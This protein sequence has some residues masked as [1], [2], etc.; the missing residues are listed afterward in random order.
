MIGNDI[1][2]LTIAKIES[3]WN[4]PRFLNKIFTEKEQQYIREY[5]RPERMVWLLWS[6]KESAYKLHFQHNKKR[7]YAPKKFSCEMR[8]LNEEEGCGK[9]FFGDF[10][11]FT[12]SALSD[13][14]V[15]TI[16]SLEKNKKYLSQI[17]KMRKP[18][19]NAQ[20]AE[21][22]SGAIAQ[23]AEYSGKSHDKI[24][25]KK[26]DYGI[27]FLYFKDEKAKTDISISHHGNY[28]AFAIEMS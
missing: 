24:Y 18:K 22:Y 8:Y 4:R 11:C 3:E 9:V 15:Y 26:N 28:G 7:F 14:F 1:V 13:K 17:I 21:V 20:H 27:P 19:Y 12:Q 23:F 5:P 25:I 10:R 6:M 16:T 2:D